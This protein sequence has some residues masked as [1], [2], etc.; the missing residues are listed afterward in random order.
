MSVDAAALM[1]PMPTAVGAPRAV[2]VFVLAGF[3]ALMAQVGGV[4]VVQVVGMDQ[5]IPVVLCRREMVPRIA[6]HLEALVDV[7]QLV[8]ARVPLPDKG[9]GAAQCRAQQESVVDR[10]AQR[11][12]ADRSERGGGLAQRLKRHQRVIVCGCEAEHANARREVIQRQPPAAVGGLSGRAFPHGNEGGTGLCRHAIDPD[13]L[14]VGK[15]GDAGMATLLG[16]MAPQQRQ[17]MRRITVRDLVQQR[18]ARQRNPFRGV[19]THGG[20]R[21]VSGR[22][23]VPRPRQVGSAC[24]S[25]GIAP[26]PL[27]ARR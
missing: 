1:Q 2:D 14:A 7:S 16:Q 18:L 9:A 20:G 12:R 3:T 11:P 24:R 25:T 5:Q 4:V 26:D 15:P 13:R 17:R 27:S 22:R 21:F 6:E 19:A 8:G 10:Q 23:C